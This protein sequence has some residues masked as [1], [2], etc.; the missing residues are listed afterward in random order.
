MIQFYS[1]EILDQKVLG[2]EESSHCIRVLRKRVGDIIF[3]TDG[4]GNRYECE[5]V[6]ADKREVKLNILNNE[7]KPKNWSNRII[8]AVA[9]T[10]N[11]D[12]M[13]WLVEKATEIGVDEIRFVQCE[14]SER[15]VV[16]IDRLRRNAV[17]AMNQSLKTQLP[18]I[19]GIDPLE[20]IYGLDGEKFY[21][22]C[23]SESNRLEFEKAYGGGDVTIAIGPEGDFSQ[24]EIEQLNGSGFKAVTFGDERLRTETAALYA[25]AATHILKNISN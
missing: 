24:T 10:K 6:Q 25:T 12:R 7:Y 22:Y 14:N 15:K 3:V 16:N 18:E 20:S 2:A 23:D 9:P 13:A 11:A 19:R 4:K 1:P 8:I 21:G 17:S 5:I